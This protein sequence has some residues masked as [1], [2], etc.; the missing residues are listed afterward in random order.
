MKTIAWI[1][2]NAGTL[3]VGLLLLAITA[4]ILRRLLKD[5]KEG[6]SACGNSCASCPMHGACHQRS[7]AASPAKQNQ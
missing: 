5:R 4:A 2:G 1:T 6:R 3:A 7:G